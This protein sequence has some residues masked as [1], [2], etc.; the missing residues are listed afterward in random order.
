MVVWYDKTSRLVYGTGSIEYALIDKNP[1]I[2]SVTWDS[3]EQ[4]VILDFE[5]TIEGEG[6]WWLWDDGNLHSYE[7]GASP[8]LSLEDKVALL[9]MDV[10]AVK[11]KP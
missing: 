3:K 11:L 8:P 5:G 2:D 1:V 10:E 6:P 4:A 9:Q 7:E